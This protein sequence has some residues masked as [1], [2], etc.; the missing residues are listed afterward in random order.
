MAQRSDDVN[1]GLSILEWT[2]KLVPQGAL[3]TGELLIHTVLRSCG[4]YMH[5]GCCCH[6][7]VHAIQLLAD[8]LCI[9]MKHSATFVTPILSPC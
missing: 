1:K 2:S 3:V 4:L 6:L 7:G 5:A 8:C 9:S